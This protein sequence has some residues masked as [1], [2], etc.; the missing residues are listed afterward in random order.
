VAAAGWRRPDAARGTRTCD[1]GPRLGGRLRLIAHEAGRRSRQESSR[2]SVAGSGRYP[3]R[4]WTGT[5]TSLRSM[6]GSGS[7]PDASPTRQRWPAAISR[8][9][10]REARPRVACWSSRRSWPRRRARR[11]RTSPAR[12]SRSSIQT[13]CSSRRA[14]GRGPHSAWRR[15]R[16]LKIS[17]RVD[18]ARRWALNG[19]SACGQPQATRSGR[20]GVTRQSAGA[21]CPRRVPGPSE[22]PLPIAWSARLVL[23]IA[24]YEGGEVPRRAELGGASTPHGCWVSGRR[25]SRGRCPTSPSRQAAG[26]LDGA[27]HSWSGPAA[28]AG[29]GCRR[30]RRRPRRGSGWRGRRVGVALGRRR[31]SHSA[32]WVTAARDARLSAEVTWRGSPCEGRT[33]DALALLEPAMPRRV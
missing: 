30:S 1:R 19:R 8:R 3:P 13:R 7:T 29:I 18:G 28:G 9:P 15:R 24:L 25:S 5:R 10:R 21:T 2:R 26:D 6:P 20:D 23:G 17:R 11:L 12:A 32:A 27:R 14:P 31:P 4:H 33:A 22:S 16:L